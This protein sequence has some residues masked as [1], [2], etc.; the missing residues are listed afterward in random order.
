MTAITYT[1]RLVILVS[2]TPP[3]FVG[4]ANVYRPSRRCFSPRVEQS[5]LPLTCKIKWLGCVGAGGNNSEYFQK[6]TEIRISELPN[7]RTCD[8]RLWIR[9]GIRLKL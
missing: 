9:Y 4:C 5:Q 6:A 7:H 2:T 1:P 8:N 3:G